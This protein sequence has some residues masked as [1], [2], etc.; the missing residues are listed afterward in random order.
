MPIPKFDPPGFLDD[1][2]QNQS[3]EWSKWISE[4][5]TAARNRED[6]ALV[7]Y[8]PR[9]QF[10]NLLSDPPADDA[11][12]GDVTWTAF[13]R[14]VMLRSG[15]SD[16]KRW[17]DADASRD[18]QDEYCE[19]SVT[20]DDDK[21]TSVSFTAEG[22]EYWEYL[23]SVDPDKV[24]SL[25]QEH[26]SPDV[27]MSDLFTG[28]SYSPRNRWNNSTAM[29]VMHLV[30]R[31]NTLGAEIE[32]AAGASIVR[33]DEQG[34]PITAERRLIECGRYGEGERNSD[35]TIGAF[36]NEL[37]RKKADVTLAN[38]VGLYIDGLS[39]AGWETPDGSEPHEYWRI[40]RGTEAKAVRAI[41]EVP[42]EKSFAVGDIKIGGQ[43]INFGSQIADFITIK[44]TGLATRIGKSTVEPFPGCLSGAP[45]FA[46]PGATSVAA[47]LEASRARIG[48]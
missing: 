34:A 22:P 6:Q 8:G 23:A 28:G 27:Q 35:P 16:L 17:R 18:N 13:P 36:V 29:G 9:L 32:L 2:D 33:L 42:P 44:V 25:Y 46:A 21:I 20:R 41:Y 5:L 1:L 10:F 24:L 40:T 30:Q 12:E 7:N 48:R 4:E 15:G 47:A 45:A 39:V 31:N 14:I 3:Q 37:A 43:E 26:V 19:W 38:P 11:V